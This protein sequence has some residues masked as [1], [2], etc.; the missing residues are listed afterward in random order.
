M[1]D[2]MLRDYVSLYISLFEFVRILICL[3]IFIERDFP[4][5]FDVTVECLDIKSINK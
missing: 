5:S 1:R 3:K 2:L 4:L